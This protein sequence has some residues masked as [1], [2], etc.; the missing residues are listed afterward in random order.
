MGGAGSSPI[1]G[2][3]GEKAKCEQKAQG[4]TEISVNL[5]NAFGA[6]KTTG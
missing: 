2:V 5:K 4:Q 6:T 1:S 3:Q